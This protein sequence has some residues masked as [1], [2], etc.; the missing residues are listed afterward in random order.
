MSQ[1][2]LTLM[3]QEQVTK[4]LEP[5]EGLTHL[6]VELGLKSE[7]FFKTD[8][9][10]A[11]VITLNKEERQMTTEGL[12]EAARGV[13]IPESYSRKCPTELLFRN[14][15]HW[16]RGG[17]A[18]KLRFFLHDGVVVGCNANRPQ[19]YNNTELLG[20][21][22]EIIGAE[23]V[24]GYHQVFS[25]LD[26]SRISIV[27]DRVFEA[28]TGDVLHGGIDLQNSIIGEHKIEIAPYICRAICVNGAI[29]YENI[30]QWSHRSDSNEPISP[31]VRNAT[32]GSLGA[33]NGEFDRIKHLTE[34][35]VEGHV[36]DTLASLFRKFGIPVRTQKEIVAEAATQ[37][38][39][40]GPKT[41]YDLY[42]S[43]TKVGTYSSRLSSSGARSLQ[44]IAGSF[45][46]EISLCPQCHQ[47]VVK[48]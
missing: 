38:G 16:Y 27:T 35:G 45:T 3:N 47:M 5:T 46:R 9:K 41:M 4:I 37:N 6:D 24:L 39:G 31:W 33:L 1:P 34:V 18:G 29:V 2:A 7:I 23:H 42:N 10:G 14:L 17:A 28:V 11:P 40:A 48:S 32:Q 15:D 19:Y 21:A 25:R 26:H 22:E 20:A 30:S 36:P 43:L 12:Q 8:D 44:S 13:G